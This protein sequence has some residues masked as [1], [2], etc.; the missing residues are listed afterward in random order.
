MIKAAEE[1]VAAVDSSK[2]QPSTHTESKLKLKKYAMC[3]MYCGKGY[4]GLQRNPGMKTIEE[5]LLKACLDAKL[6]TEDAYNN[7][8]SI[9]FQRAA[10]TD[11]GESPFLEYPYSFLIWPLMLLYRQF[12]SISRT[13]SVV[14]EVAHSKRSS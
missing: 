14:H 10:R 9:M 13:A 1:G 5:D 6:I 12:R 4:L 8:Q 3:L 7:P 2:T 11:K